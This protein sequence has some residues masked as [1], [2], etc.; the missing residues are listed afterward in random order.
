MLRRDVIM[1]Y[2]ES[3]TF[4]FK[5][6]RLNTTNNEIRQLS[7]FRSEKTIE[8][9]K[10]IANSKIP[11]N[12]IGFYYSNSDLLPHEGLVEECTNIINDVQKQLEES[13]IQNKK[14]TI[15]MIVD[16]SKV[17]IVHGHDETARLKLEA[18][19]KNVG[20][21][22]VV[23]FRQADEGNTIIEKFEKYSNVGFAI[24]L[25]TYCDDGKGKNESDYKKRA[26][27][28]VV[29]EHGY[30]I[31]KLGRNRVCALRKG[32]IEIPSDY[33][34]VIFKTMDE[35]GGWQME[36]AKELKAAGYSVDMNL[37]LQ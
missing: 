23:L 11:K 35:S 33:Q 17:F 13:G 31:A 29:F 8:E 16:N 28:N 22:P 10:Q 25:Y 32:D 2:L 7:I 15:N 1:P 21:E 34:G 37:L 19:L 14:E 26:R 18:F 36:L 27:Q 24:V 30:M 9:C 20:L 6:V 12:V 4:I 3:S 5:G